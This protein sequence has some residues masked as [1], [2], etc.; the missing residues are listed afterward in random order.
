MA[1]PPSAYKDRHFLAVIGDEVSD[2]RVNVVGQKLTRPS[3][4]S[5]RPPTGW[6]RGMHHF[7]SDGIAFVPPGN[8]KENLT[9]PFHSM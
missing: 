2:Q 8:N 5:D 3:G 4:F 7:P 1:A 6:D 9:I